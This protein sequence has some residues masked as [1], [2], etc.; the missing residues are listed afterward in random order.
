MPP[1]R[2]SPCPPRHFL[3]DGGK[4][5]GA[6]GC[7][8]LTACPAGAAQRPRVVPTHVGLACMREGWRARRHCRSRQRGEGAGASGRGANETGAGAEG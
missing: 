1:G 4:A 7:R 6:K 8:G 2:L 3:T 5:G